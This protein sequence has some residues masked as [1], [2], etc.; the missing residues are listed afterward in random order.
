MQPSFDYFKEN[1]QFDM[2]QFSQEVISV[3]EM[4]D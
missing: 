1:E 2:Q 3:P 4:V